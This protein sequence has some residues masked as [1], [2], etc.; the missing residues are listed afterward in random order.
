MTPRQRVVFTLF[1]LEEF[2][3]REIAEQLEIPEAAVVSRLR[4]G[5]EVFQNFCRRRQLGSNGPTK[6]GGN[7]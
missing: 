1:D 6:E 2:S 7:G 5:R 4:R 3:A